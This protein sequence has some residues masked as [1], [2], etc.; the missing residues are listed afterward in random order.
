METRQALVAGAAHCSDWC[1]DLNAVGG[2]TVS[3]RLLPWPGPNG[4]ACYLPSVERDTASALWRLADEME[5]VQLGMG[6]ELLGFVRKTLREAAPSETELHGM[7]THLCTALSDAL[8]V[9]DSRGALLDLP[10]VAPGRPLD[11]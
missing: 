7:V 4:Q 1:R 11:S 10:P 3:L 5:S 8:R 9:A 6:S 2:C